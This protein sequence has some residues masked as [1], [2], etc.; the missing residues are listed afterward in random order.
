MHHYSDARMTRGR[1]RMTNPLNQAQFATRCALQ[2][3]LRVG[4]RNGN[5][6]ELMRL[7]QAYIDHP[8]VPRR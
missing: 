1:H 8:A 7:A 4:M 5:L 6:K 2:A 3:G